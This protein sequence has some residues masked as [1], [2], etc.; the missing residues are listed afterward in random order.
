M[1]PRTRKIPAD[2]TDNDI[3]I[4]RAAKRIAKTVI[5]Q[6]KNGNGH[7]PRS[8]VKDLAELFANKTAVITIY[9]PRDEYAPVK[10]D[11]GYRWEIAPVW[12]REAQDVVEKYRDQIR[13]IDGKVD[14][15]DPKL[16]ESLLEQIVAC[17]KRFW[18]EPDSPEGILCE[19][20]LLTP[21]PENARRLL[22]HPDLWWLKQD[23][24][25]GYLERGL[26]FGA[27]PKTA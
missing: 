16:E 24:Q 18:Q 2:I 1:A 13:R 27:R 17:T 6:H 25:A 8:E 21:S 9:D 19:G 11:T 23:V 14:F 10:R 3:E 12:S 4:A 26:F 5:D 20:E 22:T 15:A 7:Y